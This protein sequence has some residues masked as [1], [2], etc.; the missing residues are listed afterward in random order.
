[1]K[2]I[3]KSLLKIVLVLFAFMLALFGVL[4]T[5]YNEP[6][7]TGA[8]GRKADALAQKMLAAIH[9]EDYRKTCYFEWSY[10]AG[11]HHYF[12]DKQ[13]GKVHVNWSDNTVFL[14]LNDPKKSKVIENEKEVIGKSKKEFIEKAVSYFNNDSFWLVGPFK[15]F[16]KGTRRSIVKLDD[17]TDA[18]LVKYTS[19]GTTPGDSYLWKLSETGLPE[20]FRMWVDIIPIGGLE[21]T[22]DN[23][24]VME[25]GVF[26]PTSHKFG[27]VHLDLGEVRGYN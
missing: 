19:G 20:S 24:Q 27:P 9:Y 25:S 16:D 13:K 1:M 4:Y 10:A 14:N 7:P 11:T 6:L 8:S 23:W 21:A 18:L 26:L 3:L 17:G 12:W 5:I 2:R 15:V 22:W